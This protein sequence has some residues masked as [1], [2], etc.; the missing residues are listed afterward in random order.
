MPL[1]CSALV[2]VNCLGIA[3]GHAT[4]VLVHP[5]DGILAF[6]VSCFCSPP[7]QNQSV[8]DPTVAGDFWSRCRP[9]RTLADR[10]RSANP[11]DCTVFGVAD[12]MPDGSA[13]VAELGHRFTARSIQL[14]PACRFGKTI[15]RATADAI[16]EV[17]A[18]PVGQH[19][20]PPARLPVPCLGRRNRVPASVD[21][22]WA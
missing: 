16:T 9:S 22:V 1:S 21:H 3:A 12:G 14:S 5:C 13:C 18:H 4:A 10:A 20:R 19:L 2:P 8:R 17:A 6:K 7:V 11:A 15:S